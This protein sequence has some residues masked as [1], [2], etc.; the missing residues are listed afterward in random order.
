M[1]G[2]A[3]GLGALALVAIA[4][5]AAVARRPELASSAPGRLVGAFAFLA[6]PGL[7]LVAG[8]GRH[9]EQAKTTR[10]CVSCHLIGPYEESLRIDHPAF[11]PAAHYQNRRLPAERACY[12]CHTNYTMFGD[13]DD[14]VRGVHHVWHAVFGGASDPVRL[15]RPFSNRAC[16]ECH[17]GARSYIEHPEHARFLVDLREEARS[18]LMCHNLVHEVARLDRFGRW[19]PEAPP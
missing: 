6:L 17:Q 16:L 13:F 2:A 15:Y 4:L 12:A 9:Y 10:F 7:L 19:P 5:I 3:L 18:C 11:L 1:S 8:A 14:K